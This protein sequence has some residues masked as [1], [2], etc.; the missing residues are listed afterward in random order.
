MKKIIGLSFIGLL[1]VALSAPVYAQL[2]FK[3]SGYFDTNWFYYRNIYQTTGSPDSK[4]TGLGPIYGAPSGAT[5]QQ[6][7]SG[8]I[9]NK[10]TSWVQSRGLLKF[11]AA[12][13]K[14]VSMTTYFEMDSTRWGERKVG[15]NAA[16][17]WQT[18]AAAVEIKNLYLDVAIPYF[19]IPVPMTTRIGLQPFV[20]R[21]PM[22]ITNDG[23]G[24]T[25]A[26]KMDPVTI[27][28]FWFK[29]LQSGTAND[30][31]DYTTSDDNDV[32]GIQGTATIGKLTLG[33]YGVFYNMRSY[34]L[35]A[36]TSTYGLDPSFKSRMYWFG[37]YA[38]G[39]AGPLDMKADLVYDYGV[40]KPAAGQ[41]YRDVDYR[42]YAARLGFKYPW[43]LFEFG[44]LGAYGSGSDANKTS[45]TGLPGTAV[46]NQS[47]SPGG[48]SYKVGSYVIPP[49]SEEPPGFGSEN[50]V[51]VFYQ[52]AVLGRQPDFS[53]G[54]SNV[55][56]N[57]GALGGTWLS[58]AHVG[59]KATPWYKITLL[60][61]YIGDTT[62]H[63]NTVGSA[64]KADGSL[65][66]DKT[67]GWEVGLYNEFNVYK[68]LNFNIAGAYLFGKKGL[69][70]FDSTTGRNIS[71]K[72][73]FILGTALKYTW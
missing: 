37:A 58:R 22:L 15:R 14:E 33:G 32:L 5:T 65:R 71:P 43:E 13:G 67:I 54:S 9:F 56:L 25:L 29:M 51:A 55:S 31:K 48:T 19:G 46:A 38:D 44:I 53:G 36:T 35:N 18:D 23:A 12:M 8:A 3:A 27:S 57:R 62:K 28:P 41:A 2:E 24:V 20:V 60:G 34:P 63:G 10:E 52:S 17:I 39:K 4:H 40:V 72:D 70:L 7:P 6:L 66:D 47:G 45:T 64:R 61:A 49:G 26:L 1:I 59:Y 11:D 21:R 69:E 73:P 68:N 16:G 42:G 30:A 50:G